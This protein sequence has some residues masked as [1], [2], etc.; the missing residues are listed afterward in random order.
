MQWTP[1]GAHLLLQTRTKALSG[2]LEETFRPLVSGFPQQAKAHERLHQGFIC[3][4][5]S[6]SALAADE[7]I[8][9]ALTE[10][11]VVAVNSTVVGEDESR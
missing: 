6:R 10:T 11:L 5:D 3:E 7:H 4:I 2:D 1:P 9:A 8:S